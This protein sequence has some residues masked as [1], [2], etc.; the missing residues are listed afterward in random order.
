MFS[1]IQD[2]FDKICVNEIDREDS[3]DKWIQIILEMFINIHQI[4]NYYD[5][6][7]L[8][9]WLLSRAKALCDTDDN[10]LDIYLTAILTR[11]SIHVSIF[12]SN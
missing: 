7:K 2:S 3:K 5:I 11:Y 10:M 8:F 12:I 6:N 4:D 9:L 1:V